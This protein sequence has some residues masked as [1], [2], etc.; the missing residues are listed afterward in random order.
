MIKLGRIKNF[1]PTSKNNYLE[2]L[3]FPDC[4]HLNENCKCSILEVDGCIGESCSFYKSNF[5]ERSA[6]INTMK[7]LSSLDKDKQKQ[8]ASTYYDGKMPWKNNN[9]N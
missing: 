1:I 2:P 7:R 6:E 8:I 5:E 3:G 9:K 4:I